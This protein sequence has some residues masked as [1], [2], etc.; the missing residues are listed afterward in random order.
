MKWVN[1]TKIYADIETEVSTV[2]DYTRQRFYTVSFMVDIL[3]YRKLIYRYF[4]SK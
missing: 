1:L 3:F 2:Q 4:T